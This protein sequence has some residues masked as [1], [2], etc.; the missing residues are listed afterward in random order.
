LVSEWIERNNAKTGLRGFSA[1]SDRQDHHG[2]WIEAALCR[3]PIHSDSL[4]AIVSKSSKTR[5][6]W[7][8]PALGGDDFMH[9]R[10][11]ITGHDT[12][13]EFANIDIANRKN[14][15]K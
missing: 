1:R 7:H 4:N 12:V 9:A 5:R 15:L 3:V 6:C 11:W 10:Y 13:R 8:P 14:V 2:R